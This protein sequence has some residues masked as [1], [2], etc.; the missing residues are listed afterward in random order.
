MLHRTRHVFRACHGCNSSEGKER[1]L[2]WQ[3]PLQDL[4]GIV[5][6]ACQQSSGKQRPAWKHKRSSTVR[7]IVLVLF[8]LF[9]LSSK[10]GSERGRSET[11][12]ITK[13]K[14]HTDRT[15]WNPGIFSGDA[16]VYV[17][18]KSVDLMLLQLIWHAGRRSS[19]VVRGLYVRGLSGHAGPR[20]QFVWSQERYFPFNWSDISEMER[21]LGIKNEYFHIREWRVL[22]IPVEAWM[23]SNEMK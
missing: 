13:T 21:R 20:M 5:S 7:S 22:W 18:C 8:Q 15:S 2:S 23:P 12:V 10:A 16:R 4:S 19:Q 6:R 17:I 14:I 9:T 11:M 1:Q 3:S